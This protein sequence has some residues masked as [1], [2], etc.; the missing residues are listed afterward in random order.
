MNDW[1]TSERKSRLFVQQ[2][3]NRMEL[4]DEQMDCAGNPLGWLGVVVLV[5]LTVIILWR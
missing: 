1:Y 4:T 5:W 3:Q 2:Y